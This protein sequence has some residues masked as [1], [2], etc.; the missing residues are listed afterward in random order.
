MFNFVLQLHMR[1]ISLIIQFCFNFSDF[2]INL[3]G[4]A[5]LNLNHRFKVK[6]SGRI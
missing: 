4:T 2:F 6:D 3:C 5:G 1:K